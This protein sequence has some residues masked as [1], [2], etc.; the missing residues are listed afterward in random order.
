MTAKIALYALCVTY[1]SLY[2]QVI[3]RHRSVGSIY[4]RLYQIAF[5]LGQTANRDK[6]GNEL[7]RNGRV[8]RPGR[9]LDRRRSVVEANF[10]Y[11]RGTKL[12]CTYRPEK[13][14]CSSRESK[15]ELSLPTNTVRYGNYIPRNYVYNIVYNVT[16]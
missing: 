4:R 10:D 13:F 2:H 11:R 14:G 1:S 9:W 6:S 5:C 8:G 3:T 7:G 15:S 16:P 12:R